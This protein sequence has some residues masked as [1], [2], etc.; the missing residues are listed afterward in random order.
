MASRIQL[1]RTTVAGNAPHSHPAAV[2]ANNAP[3][4]HTVTVDAGNAPHTHTVGST[5]GTE[6]RPRNI[7]LM[8]VIKY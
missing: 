7:S 4:S 5:G 3:H 2:V 8:V 1:K 6:T